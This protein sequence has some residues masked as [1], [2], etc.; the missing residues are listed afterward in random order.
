MEVEI[1]EYYPQKILD[2]SCELAGSL[3]IYVIDYGL[4]IRGISVRK[5]KGKYYFTL[6]FRPALDENGEQIIE[7]G[8]RIRYP[9]VMFADPEKQTQLMTA[10]RTQ[11]PTFI[12]S[13][14]KKKMPLESNIN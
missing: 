8:R 12:E 14:L 5:S 11:G 9:I 2:K 3:S 10:L 13:K 7:G 6:P 1:Q 4:D